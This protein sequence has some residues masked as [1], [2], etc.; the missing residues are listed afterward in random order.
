M[1]SRLCV[2]V[3]A[4]LLMVGPLIA[5]TVERADASP[6]S[7]YVGDGATQYGCPGGDVSIPDPIYV[8][9]TVTFDATVYF[10]SPATGISEVEWYTSGLGPPFSQ[11]NSGNYFIT[12]VFQQPGHAGW[13]VIIFD[14]LGSEGYVCPCDPG[15]SDVQFEVLPSLTPLPATLPLFATGFGVMGLFGWR[16]KRNAQTS[17]AAP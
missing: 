5:S 6:F 4:I 3:A 13:Q 7:C 12:G 9:E 15:S 2:I 17:R 10:S 11:T 16:R 14:N 8:G 1:K